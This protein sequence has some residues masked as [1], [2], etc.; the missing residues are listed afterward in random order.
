MSTSLLLYRAAH[1]GAPLYAD[2]SS[3]MQYQNKVGLAYKLH[4]TRCG[5]GAR[6]AWLQDDQVLAQ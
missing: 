5:K 4:I 3:Q 2:I 1:G 6:H